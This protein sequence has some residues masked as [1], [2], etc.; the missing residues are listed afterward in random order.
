M[1]AAA[2]ALALTNSIDISRFTPV[3]WYA[4]I[5]S[6]NC[7]HHPGYYFL[8]YVTTVAQSALLSGSNRSISYFGMKSML[9][10]ADIFSYNS[11]FI[12]GSET[13]GKKSHYHYLYYRSREA[14]TSGSKVTFPASQNWHQG[15]L[16]L[17][18]DS[19]VLWL[20]SLWSAWEGSPMS[21]EDFPDRNISTAQVTCK[22]VS[23]RSDHIMLVTKMLVIFTSLGTMHVAD[24]QSF[25]R[26]CYCFCK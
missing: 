7:V 2:H 3:L 1:F 25:H 19:V 10:A 24:F 23:I 18:S 11:C 16:D 15:Q 9:N 5:N 13:V 8:L 22:P 4:S 21:P 6:F 17:L 26:Y 14:N 20:F 12:H